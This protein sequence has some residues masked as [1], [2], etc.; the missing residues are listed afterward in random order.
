MHSESMEL[1]WQFCLIFINLITTKTFY[2][3]CFL[4]F[5]FKVLHMLGRHF[6]TCAM[7]QTF[8]VIFHEYLEMLI[9]KTFN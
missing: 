7:P 3:F 1:A 8:Y 2:V 5:E 6:A 4:G 9:V